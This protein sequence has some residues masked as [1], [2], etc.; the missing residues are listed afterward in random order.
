MYSQQLAQKPITVD[1]FAVVLATSLI[2]FVITRP[3]INAVITANSQDSLSYA[4]ALIPLGKS[5][6]LLLGM[7]IG[8]FLYTRLAFKLNRFIVLLLKMGVGS[9]AGIVGT[10]LLL[11]F[12]TVLLLN[13][14]IN[15]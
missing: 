12:L 10:F 11:A 5:C 8:Y 13:G 4:T 14:V 2:T 3:T 1:R 7:I 15:Y 9:A 6:L